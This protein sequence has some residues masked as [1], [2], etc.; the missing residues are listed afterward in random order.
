M[1]T[2]FIR[3]NSR[4]RIK[5]AYLIRPND[6]DIGSKNSVVPA[7]KIHLQV[8]TESNSIKSAF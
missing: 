7:I 1:A 5:D 6:V 2:V 4:K 3:S 8:T